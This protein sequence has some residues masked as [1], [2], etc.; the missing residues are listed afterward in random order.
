MT[1]VTLHRN[2]RQYSANLSD[3]LSIAIPLDF[4]GAQPNHFSAPRAHAAALTQ[5][6]WI[7]DVLAGGSVN[8][9]ALSLVPHCNGTHTECVGHITEDR[10]AIHD[11]LRGG[12]H[13]ARL[14][15][16]TPEHRAATSETVDSS[17]TPDEYVI[18]AS[19]LARA[20]ELWNGH[21]SALVLRT[22]PNDTSKL[23]KTYEGPAPAPYLTAEAA[24]RLVLENIEHIVTDLPS[25]DRAHDAGRLLAHRIFWG[26][27]APS[28]RSSDA[29]RGHATITELAWIAPT[30]RDGWYLLDLQMPAFVSDAAP[31]RPLLYPLRPHD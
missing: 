16:V 21:S 2:G 15:T 30:I 28:R 8:C 13:L 1:D 22:R 24:Q 19:E 29:R 7:G 11:V 31:S 5:G 20:L 17:A 10:V 26:L 4:D 3:P 6:R 14:V 27:D 18:T 12:L 23:N 9:S 25:L